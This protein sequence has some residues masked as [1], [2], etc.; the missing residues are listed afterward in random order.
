MPGILAP[1]RV[2]DDFAKR[3]SGSA[4]TIAAR[5]DEEERGPPP[6][7]GKIFVLSMA[8]D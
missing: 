6:I 2:P 5:E 3:R 4:E 7:L 1:S 8:R